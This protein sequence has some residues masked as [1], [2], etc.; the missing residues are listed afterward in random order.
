MSGGEDLEELD[1][2]HCWWEYNIY[3]CFEKQEIGFLK[4]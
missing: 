3:N 2:L 4:T 1:L